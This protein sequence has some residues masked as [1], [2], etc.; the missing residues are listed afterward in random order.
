[1]ILTI[2][3]HAAMLKDYYPQPG[4]RIKQYVVDERRVHAWERETCPMLN[5]PLHY[6]DVDDT[7]ATSGHVVECPSVGETSWLTIQ[8]RATS[9]RF[10]EGFM[11]AA[12][13]LPAVVDWFAERASYVAEHPICADRSQLSDEIAPDLGAMGDHPLLRMLK[14]P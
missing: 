10:C 8:A 7:E 3:S 5:V 11:F 14:R 1:M 6:E 13:G 4:E 9:C 2:D 12:S